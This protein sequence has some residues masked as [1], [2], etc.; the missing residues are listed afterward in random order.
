MVNC[1]WGGGGG[2]SG[3]GIS[4]SMQRKFL[5]ENTRKTLGKQD[6]GTDSR[7]S[8]G[9]NRP[10]GKPLRYEK[11]EKCRVIEPISN[12][13]SNNKGD[14]QRFGNSVKVNTMSSQGKPR[15]YICDKD[16]HVISTNKRGYARTIFCR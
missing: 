6:L 16:D 9:R 13:D 1:T 5:R 3:T 15:C 7:S 4:E 11:I 2:G 14:V 8:L 10:R 12:R